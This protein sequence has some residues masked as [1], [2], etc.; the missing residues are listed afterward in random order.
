MI[1]ILLRKYVIF[2]IFEIFQDIRFLTPS[3]RIF[4]GFFVKVDMFRRVS[5]IVGGM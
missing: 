5:L 3:K 1:V 4:E 2:E